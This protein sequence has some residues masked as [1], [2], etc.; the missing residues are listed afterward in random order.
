M[1]VT[2]QGNDESKRN[3]LCFQDL[4][5][6]YIFGIGN[7]LYTNRYDVDEW[8]TL[9]DYDQ[10]NRR[11]G[12]RICN[13]LTLYGRALIVPIILN[14]IFHINAFYFETKNGNAKTWEFIFVLLLIYPQYRC[15]KIIFHFF[16]HKNESKLQSEK[17][18]Y[19]RNI[20]SIEACV[21]SALQVL[22]YYRYI[23]L[24]SFV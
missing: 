7:D 4:C 9:M 12:G 20:E 23:N 24:L 2:K 15:M 5:S 6:S 18:T 14:M 22:P 1:I 8:K 17:E 19:E 11:I 16:Y 10:Y 13:L 21:E 3:K